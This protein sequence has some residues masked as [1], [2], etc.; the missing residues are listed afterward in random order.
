VEGRRK[1]APMRRATGLCYVRLI[2]EP[3]DQRPSKPHEK[4]V[5][6][7]VVKVSHEPQA[8]SGLTS[9]TLPGPRHSNPQNCA[10][11]LSTALFSRPKRAPGFGIGLGRYLPAAVANA[12]MEYY[13]LLRKRDRAKELNFSN[14]V[15][16]N[17]GAMAS[18]LLQ[19]AIFPLQHSPLPR[20]ATI[21]PCL[22]RHLCVVLRQG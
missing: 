20:G 12:I 6:K 19:K 16:R 4:K 3:G 13:R 1:P 10:T 7:I 2:S 21:F 15:P 9:R 5:G 8:R 18:K 22:R 11:G 14:S 17:R